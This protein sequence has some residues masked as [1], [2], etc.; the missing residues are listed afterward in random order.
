MTWFFPK[1]KSGVKQ[2]VKSRGPILRLTSSEKSLRLCHVTSTLTNLRRV[3]KSCL[4]QT[5]QLFW[6]RH[7]FLI[8]LRLYNTNPLFIWFKI[9]I[10]GYNQNIVLTLYFFIFLGKGSQTQA[11]LWIGTRITPFRNLKKC[12]NI[13]RLE[14]FHQNIL[15]NPRFFEMTVW[16]LLEWINMYHRRAITTCG[17]Y[18][19]YV[20]T[21]TR[22]FLCF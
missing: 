13:F 5:E 16:S 21:F 14:I 22:R 17:L 3:S 12:K 9:K 1:T 20:S 15:R 2:G 8:K 11:R 10:K 4:T 18:I 7:T 6:W 19:F